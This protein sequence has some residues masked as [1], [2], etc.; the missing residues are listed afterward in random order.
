MLGGLHRTTSHIGTKSS[1]NLGPRSGA[2]PDVWRKRGAPH[3]ELATESPSFATV[4]P[5]PSNC[6]ALLVKHPC[7]PH[8]T[9]LCSDWPPIVRPWPSTS[10]TLRWNL[11][12]AHGDTDSAVA[13]CSRRR[14][15]LCK[16]ALSSSVSA[17]RSWTNFWMRN[18][19]LSM[20]ASVSANCTSK[21]SSSAACFA[22]VNHCAKLPL[23]GPDD[24]PWQPM[25]PQTGDSRPCNFQCC[26][27]IWCTTC[28]RRILGHHTWLTPSTPTAP[29]FRHSIL[30]SAIRCHWPTN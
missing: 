8:P 14:D 7:W 2:T 30:S 12:R 9:N 23:L 6:S 22:F 15:C 29:L 28:R 13:I 4:P 16:A 5:P 18:R 19:D 11:A 1:Y 10:P 25:P 27:W 21:G 24:F 26:V 20:K 3:C 17:S